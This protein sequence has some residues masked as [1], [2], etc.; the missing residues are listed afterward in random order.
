MRLRAA[1]QLTKSEIEAVPA[2]FNDAIGRHSLWHH[3]SGFS[4]FVGHAGA[5]LP[6]RLAY[7]RLGSSPQFGSET[8]GPQLIESCKRSGKQLLGV[9][10]I[11]QVLGPLSGLSFV[12]DQ[13]FLNDV[14]D[15]VWNQQQLA[16]KLCIEACVI[17]FQLVMRDGRV[18]V[19]D[20]SLSEPGFEQSFAQA[21]L[22]SCHSHRNCHVGIARH[23]GQVR[24]WLRERMTPE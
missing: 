8:A 24:N 7:S 12:R 21:S 6:H 14:A 18:I 17:V 15:S 20:E 4:G 3:A 23:Q 19:A 22:L 5:Q 9:V 11:E 1:S 2:L 10:N 16:S 13:Q